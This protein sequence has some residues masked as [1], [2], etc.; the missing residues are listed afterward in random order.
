MGDTDMNRKINVLFVGETWM[1]ETTEYKGF[2]RFTVSGYRTAVKWIQKAL[3]GDGFSFTHIPCHEVDSRFPTTLNELKEYDVVLVSDCGSNTFLLHEDTFFDCRTTVNKLNLIKEYVEQ[4]G[5]FGMIGGYLTFQGFEGKGKY[6][7]T[8]IEEILPVTLQSGDDRIELPEGYQISIDPSAHEIFEKIPSVFPPILGYNKLTAKKD[9]I[10][11][12]ERN[13]DA[14]I[15]IREY[16]NGRTLAYATDCSPHWA[17]PEFCE[18][19]HY[20][21]LWKN[22]VRWMTKV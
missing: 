21:T 11:L 2:D 14:L 6:K 17:S 20:G 1:F 13:G 8:A 7:G 19:E 12:A 15:A 4:G 16:G 3:S 9:A 18:W 10:V 5:A 22:I